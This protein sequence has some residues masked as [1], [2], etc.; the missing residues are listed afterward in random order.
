MSWSTNPWPPP[1]PTRGPLSR[2]SPGNAVVLLVCTKDKTGG[3]LLYL[4]GYAFIPWHKDMCQIISNGCILSYMYHNNLCAILMTWRIKKIQQS[5]VLQ[6]NNNSIF[7]IGCRREFYMLHSSIYFHTYFSVLF[8]SFCFQCQVFL[9]VE[10]P[11]LIHIFHLTL[12]STVS[13]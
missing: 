7:F 5:V 8:H 12:V 4:F 3:L 2:C 10:F 11:M 13:P 9:H 1:N 6:N